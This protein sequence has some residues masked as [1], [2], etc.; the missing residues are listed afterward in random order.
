MSSQSR[1]KSMADFLTQHGW[2]YE[3]A[4]PLANDA[5]FRHYFRLKNGAH[6]AVLMD[7]PPPREKILPFVSIARHLKTLGYSAPDILAK[8]AINGFLL[9]EDFGDQTFARVLSESGAEDFIERE[10]HLYSLA[11]DLLADLH[12]KPTSQTVPNY[13]PLY[14]T[15]R[16]VN[17]VLL[18]TDWFIP[19]LTG[20]Q[21]SPAAR[22]DYVA[23]WEAVT[24]QLDRSA[25]TLVLRDFHI[26][27]L[28]Y[29]H[30]NFG[31]QRCGLLDFQDALCGHPA[32]DLMSL[33]EDAR[34]DIAPELQADMLKRYMTAMPD[35]SHPGPAQ[36]KFLN[37]FFILAAQRHAKV[38]GI[39]TRL[40]KRDGKNS[41]MVHLPRVWELLES[42]LGHP[43]LEPVE[44]WIN[45]NVAKELRIQIK[46]RAWSA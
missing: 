30:E 13:L 6:G 5:S 19:S 28:M 33:L 23:R 32:Y 36:D 39:F 18:L 21:V 9:L 37:A 3:D 10:R 46:T 11:I 38:I 44:S 8:D 17:E 24:N 41:Y 26:D 2:K 43:L 22:K 16:L 20:K 31:L 1:S 45:I 12:A 35:L 7:A 4:I 29:L 40:S 14:N 27:N 25:V 34:R 42:S 15:E